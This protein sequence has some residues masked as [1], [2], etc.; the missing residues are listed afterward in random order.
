ML[1]LGSVGLL[2]AQETVLFD[3]DFESG[4][5]DNWTLVDADGDGNNWNAVNPVYTNVQAHS[6]DYA[7]YSFSWS[8]NVAYTPDNY[9][10]SPLVE[11]ATKINYFVAVN[12]DF[13]DHYGVAVSST[14]TDP[15]DFTVVFEETVLDAGW[16]EKNVE[17]PAGT[18]YVAFRH[19][20]SDDK[21]FLLIDDVYITATINTP[22]VTTNWYAILSGM[23]FGNCFYSFDLHHFLETGVVASGELRCHAGSYAN[24]YFWGVL[25][26]D[27]KNGLYKAPVDNQNKTLG[28]WELVV[29]ELSTS[30]QC[31]SFNPDDGMMYFFDIVRPS[32]DQVVPRL[33]RFNLS[34]PAGTQT[35]INEMDFNPDGFAINRNGDAYCL[36]NGNLFR[37]N[38]TNG[39]TIMV[40]STGFSVSNNHSLAFDLE[41]NE[42]IWA[43]NKNSFMEL[44]PVALYK[45][46]TETAAVQHIG[47]ING[48]FSVYCLFSVPNDESVADTQGNGIALWP[49]PAVN[50]LYLEDMDDE[51]VSV[52]DN[53][54]RLVMQES[55]KGQLD[56]SGLAPG[57]YVVAVGKR[58]MRFV[59]E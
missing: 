55:Y 40:G 8:S 19:Y 37:V 2:R 35:I 42:L 34:D 36:K 21:N 23:G 16:I 26:E 54:G 44:I 41:T 22:T 10:V 11:G 45:V 29:A 43:M 47:D 57:L 15:S 56:V 49:N 30:I 38:L 4:N 13:P 1:F 50:T 48:C 51:M 53:N 12:A 32:D 14:G 5:L 25:Y 24:G 9:M 27:G 28:E 31:M 7:A 20:D 18:K 17:L 6:G 39:S 46:D 58:A 59:K 3:D 52:Y 33:G